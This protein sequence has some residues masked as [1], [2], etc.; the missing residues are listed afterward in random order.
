M[1]TLLA[2]SFRLTGH[3]RQAAVIGLLAA[4]LSWPA[5]AADKPPRFQDF[6]A[7]HIFK[8]KPA[9][10]DVNSRPDARMFR[11][12]LRTQAAEG[13]DFAGHYKI[14]TWGCGS[15]CESFAIVDSITGKVWFPPVLSEISWNGWDGDDYGLKFKLTSKLLV[16]HGSRGEEPATGSF[17]YL[18][19]KN[20]LKLIRA[21]IIRTN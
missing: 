1:N 11:T 17:Y 18:W 10:V 4:L 14:A 12:Q 7:T 3:I 8:G 15:S 9:R 16:L 21:D 2:I 6:P 5:H 13:P 20:K 19:E